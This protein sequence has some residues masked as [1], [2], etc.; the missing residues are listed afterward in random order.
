[1]PK[2][3]GRLAV[4]GKLL[5]GSHIPIVSDAI[6]YAP[7]ARCASTVHGAW[8][9]AIGHAAAARRVLQAERPKFVLL[10]AWSWKDSVF[11]KH[12]FKARL[13][14]PKSCAERSL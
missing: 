2:R 6:L 10:F 8:L 3:K 13:K 1:L 9:C 12:D 5:P 14:L 11:K 4:Q 7:E